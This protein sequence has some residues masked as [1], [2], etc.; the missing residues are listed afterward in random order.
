M[1]ADEI[2]KMLTSMTE[3]IEALGQ[4]SGLLSSLDEWNSQLSSYAQ[5]INSGVV[6]P[7][8]YTVLALFI[9]LE[10]YNTTQRMA[11]GPGSNTYGIQQV[12]VV[13]IKFV[14]CKLAIDYSYDIVNTLFAVSGQ[15]TRGI[16]AYVG[17]GQVEAGL[18]IDSVMAGLETGWTAQISAWSSMQIATVVLHFLSIAVNTIVAARFVELYLY[19]ALAAL[20]ITT[21]CNQELHGIGLNFLKSYMAVSIQGALLYL[22]IGFFPALYASLGQAGNDLTSQAWA[23]VGQTFILALAALSTGKWAR[24]ICNAM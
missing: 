10:L 12:A 5:A 24:S 2:Q 19:T 13:M 18:D 14:L 20:P 16:A 15:I 6:K 21:F 8:A 4:N 3:I 11:A 17:S 1:F 23:L 9:L 7:L 22:V